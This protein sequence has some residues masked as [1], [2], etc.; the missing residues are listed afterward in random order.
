MEDRCPIGDAPVGES[1]P[2]TATPAPA[3]PTVGDRKPTTGDRNDFIALASPIADSSF[4][5][6]ILSNH[7]STTFIGFLWVK[8]VGA[9]AF[10]NWGM[11]KLS[12]FF[13]LLD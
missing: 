2:N 1:A 3:F 11:N 13:H 5:K 8:F 12:S 4:L 9:N 7:F 10:G 6:V